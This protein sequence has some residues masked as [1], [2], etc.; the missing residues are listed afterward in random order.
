MDRAHDSRAMVLAW[1]LD[2]FLVDAICGL[3]AA[4]LPRQPS[5]RGVDIRWDDATLRCTAGF[6]PLQFAWG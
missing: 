6:A 2:G 5:A 3:A 4:R 1:L